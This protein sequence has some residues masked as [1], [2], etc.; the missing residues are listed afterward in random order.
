MKRSF[1]N[2]YL[3]HFCDL[4]D[5][6]FFFTFMFYSYHLLHDQYLT[7]AQVLSDCKAALNWME[8]ELYITFCCKVLAREKLSFFSV[9]DHSVMAQGCGS[10]QM[11]LH[12]YWEP[13]LLNLFKTLCGM[14]ELT[15]EV[16]ETCALAVAGWMGLSQI[17]KGWL[18]P[19]IA[20]L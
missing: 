3:N 2:H 5:N 16:W 20:I 14:G 12:M 11:L 4:C 9:V 15:Q 6:L 19:P 1:L 10:V 13:F 18:N 17:E 8:K 7:L